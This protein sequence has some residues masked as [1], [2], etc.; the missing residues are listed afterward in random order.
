MQEITHRQRVLMALDHQ[1][2]D[3]IPIDFGGTTGSGIFA[4]AYRVLK[5][6]LGIVLEAPIL[7]VYP[8]T[9]QVRVDLEVVERFGADLLPVRVEGTDLF[10][11]AD[12]PIPSAHRGFVDDYGVVFDWPEG[13]PYANAIVSPLAA[14][15][16]PTKVAAHAWP[17]PQDPGRIE[18]LRAQVEFLRATDD[19]A[20]VV[21]L[22]GRFL[23]FGQRLCGYENWMIY[24]AAE[25]LFVEALMDKA[26]EVQIGICEQVLGEVGDEIDVVMFADDLGTQRNLQVSPRS[27]RSVIKPRQKELF[28]VVK[29]CTG[30]KVYLHSDGAIASILPDLIEVGV[31]IINPVQPSCEGM[32]L[33]ELKRDF[34]RDITFWGA[35]DTQSVL[36]FGSPADVRD[37]VRRRID[38]LAAGGG[39]V[40]AAVHNIQ[41]EVPAEN[42]VAMFEAAMRYGVY[43]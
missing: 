4:D 6:Q 14:P 31:D 21:G 39:Y 37:E 25:P 24:L 8:H 36:P 29:R 30:A 17:D 18:G 1:E 11:Y 43:H 27:Y 32:N 33:H 28:D 9:D 2:A 42:I 16:D 41:P 40:L 22:P 34:G 26:L 35:I 5:E 19:R 23:S 38:Q 10:H 13:S 3:R 7:R 12:Q 20:L 15:P